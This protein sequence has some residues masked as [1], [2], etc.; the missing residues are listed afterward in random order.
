[1]FCYN[2]GKEVE[3][4]DAFCPYCGANLNNNAPAQSAMPAPVAPAPAR[5]SVLAPVGFGSACLAM[6]LVL[7][8]LLSSLDV[9]FLY[10]FGFILGI[11][12]LILSI[13][14][15]V[16][17]N[18]R[19]KNKTGNGLALAGIVLSGA[20]LVAVTILVFVASFTALVA[21]GWLLLL[22]SYLG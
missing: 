2:C 9:A 17:N 5:M 15:L 10:V 8:I 19:G 6:M 14:G 12:G 16:K 22:L 21:F 3:E 20:A 4:A 18:K 1:M 13:I 7:G 11:A